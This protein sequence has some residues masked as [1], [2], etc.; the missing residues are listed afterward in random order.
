MIPGVAGSSPVD[1]PFFLID[2]VLMSPL[3]ALILGVVQGVTEF[4]PI[5]SSGHLKIAQHLLGLEK[6][7]LISFDL[8]CHL[9]TLVA[10]CTVLFRDI[11]ELLTKRRQTVHMLTVALI[12][13]IPA[14]FLFKGAIDYLFGAPENLWLFFLMTAGLLTLADRWGPR[15]KLAPAAGAWPVTF[16][17][18]QALAI[19]CFQALALAPGLSRSGSTITAARFFGWR[20]RDAVR[21][22]YLLALPTVAGGAL[23]EG[24]K[25]TLSE[26]STIS[27]P[28]YLIGFGASLMVGIITL[29]WFLRFVE[30]QRLYI[31]AFYCLAL[32]IISFMLFL[33]FAHL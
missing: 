6:E 24:R 28:A 19:G 5:S 27:L 17:K 4:L 11:I 18:K 9:G 23:L 32:A 16:S 22:S 14:Y 29:K 33:P 30:S 1:R 8:C 12:P 25:I 10:M 31:F 7:G 26:I 20:V 13:L 15:E 2:V 3:A 21:F